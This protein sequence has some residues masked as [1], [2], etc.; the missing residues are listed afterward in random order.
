MEIRRVSLNGL[1]SDVSTFLQ[2]ITPTLWRDGLFLLRV[3]GIYV[4]FKVK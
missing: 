3:D 2:V 1:C 4:L